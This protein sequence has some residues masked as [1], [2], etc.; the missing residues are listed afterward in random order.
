MSSVFQLMSQQFPNMFKSP[1]GENSTSPALG[2]GAGVVGGQT[3]QKVVCTPEVSLYQYTSPEMAAAVAA[4]GASAASSPSSSGGPL[5]R[6]MEEKGLVEPSPGNPHGAIVNVAGANGGFQCGFCG[7]TFQQKNTFQNHLRSHREGDDPYQ[8]DICGKT[9]AVPARLTRH[10]R[11]HTGEKPYQCEYC[12]KSFSVKENLSVHRRI[13]TKERPYKC[14]VCERAFEHSG[15]LHRHMRIHTGERPHRCQICQKTF[16]QSGQLVIHMRTHTGEKPYVCKTC[17]KGFTCSKQL[18]VHTRTHTGEKPYTC[19]ICGKSFGYNHVLKLHQV[20]HYGEKV[21]K[22]TLC[23]GTFNSKKSLETHIKTHSDDHV[24]IGAGSPNHH[25]NEPGVLSPSSVSQATPQSQNSDKENRE[26]S[27]SELSSQNSPPSNESPKTPPSP[28]LMF[29]S[30]TSTSS[31]SA[32]GHHQHQPMHLSTSGV[33]QHRSSSSYG[34]FSSRL[35]GNS[36]T[37]SDSTTTSSRN[38]NNSNSS[39][40]TSSQ[41]KTSSA[42]PIPYPMLPPGVQIQQAPHSRTTFL[43]VTSKLPPHPALNNNSSSSSSCISDSSPPVSPPLNNILVRQSHLS[44]QANTNNFIG[45]TNN[46]NNVNK[47][48]MGG[49]QNGSNNNNNNNSNK[50]ELS[51]NG[52]DDMLMCSIREKVQAYTEKYGYG[53]A[54]QFEQQRLAQKRFLEANDRLRHRDSSGVS[55]H[56]IMSPENLSFS[57]SKGSYN[58]SMYHQERLRHHQQRGGRSPS[59]DMIQERLSRQGGGYTPGGVLALALTKGSKAVV[60]A[61]AAAAN[62]NIPAKVSLIPVN[63]A[64][65]SGSMFNAYHNQ[66]SRL[67]PRSSSPGSPIDFNQQ[68]GHGGMYEGSDSPNRSLHSPSPNSTP[69]STPSLQEDFSDPDQMKQSG[70]D[71]SGDENSSSSSGTVGTKRARSPNSNSSGGGPRKRSSLILEKYAM[72]NPASPANPPNSESILSQRLRLSSVI[73]Y[74]EKCS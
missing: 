50:L 46:N 72:E 35:S 14:E 66:F 41:D 58:E 69:R 11:T 2:R 73:Q 49:N 33:D 24:S 52:R 68:Q 47:V 62:H 37:N 61:A 12:N 6:I 31:S 1:P 28:P 18:K 27:D 44:P 17:G 21:Y 13:H 45:L 48:Y 54:G 20:A 8:C 43:Y 30:S 51:G 34:S 57:G 29:S 3:G 16:I 22:C 40:N 7:K 53:P 60:E 71:Y 39:S 55:V 59:P 38:S 74:A 64:G 5:A 63:M 25:I 70:G 65:G 42:L 26:C 23:N 4:A 56:P 15:K 32:S 9:F 19:D 67:S 36:K 10:Y